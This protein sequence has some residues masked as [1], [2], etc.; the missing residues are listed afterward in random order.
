[1]RSTDGYISFQRWRRRTGLA[2][3]KRWLIAPWR[4]FVTLQAGLLTGLTAGITAVVI[5]QIGED[6]PHTVAGGA[7]VALCYLA[8]FRINHVM[9]FLRLRMR[10]DV[11]KRRIRIRRRGELLR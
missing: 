9:D 1:G 8:F 6:L 2:Q 5:T 10:H 7:L 3:Y 4:P 11:R